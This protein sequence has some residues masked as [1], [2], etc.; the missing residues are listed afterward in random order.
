[1][2]FLNNKLR[3][4]TIDIDYVEY[5]HNVDNEVYFENTPEYKN[6]P[7]VGVI[8]TNNGY[9]YFIP[10]TSAKEKHKKLKNS[11]DS[12]LLI[13]ENLTLAQSM[14][15]NTSAWIYNN[16]EINGVLCIKHI[17]S[18]L[19]LKKMIPVPTGAYNKTDIDSLTSNERKRLLLKEYEFLLP[20]QDSIVKK[21]EKMYCKQMNTNVIFPG[22]CNF[23]K[24]EE[25]CDNYNTSTK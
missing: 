23:K 14:S 4:Y 20:K 1:M 7:Y 16:I 22:Y 6:K 21:V 18:L 17:L 2:E 24:L 11:S 3:L 9:N 10:L 19:D 15:V 25:L 13:Y 12:H 5:L 8:I